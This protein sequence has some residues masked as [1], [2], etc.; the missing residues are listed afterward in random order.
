MI[1][2]G[3]FSEMKCYADNGSVKDFIVDKVDYDKG[4]IISYMRKAQKL[5]NKYYGGK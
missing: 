4:K 2:I 5:I 1:D 3:C